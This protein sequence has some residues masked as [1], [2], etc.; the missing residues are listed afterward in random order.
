M[1]DRP[2]PLLNL[3][4]TSLPNNNSTSSLSA[5]TSQLTRNISGLSFR[6]SPSEKTFCDHDNSVLDKTDIKTFKVDD[7]TLPSIDVEQFNKILTEYKHSKSQDLNN[8]F[9]K[10]FDELVIVDCRFQY[11][12]QGGRIDGAVNLSSKKELED[13]FLHDDIAMKS[14]IEMTQQS[15]K[16]LVFHCEFSSHRGPLMATNLRTWDRLLNKEFY[17]NLYYPDIVI[18]DGGYKKYY[19]K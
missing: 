14:P 3:S 9:L 2:R 15:R 6:M 10:F 16:L 11:E 8:K 1:C 18:L 19:E 7:C 5:G 4:T 17:P 13:Y 12:F